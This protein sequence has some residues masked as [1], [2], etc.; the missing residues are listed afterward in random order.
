[1]AYLELAKWLYEL[2][3]EGIDIHIDNDHVFRLVCGSGHLADCQMVISVNQDSAYSNASRNH[4]NIT[5][6]LFEE[7]KKEK[8]KHFNCCLDNILYVFIGLCNKI[9]IEL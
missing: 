7:K 3:G 6:W 8:T 5:S 9:Y 2:G 4:M 1:M